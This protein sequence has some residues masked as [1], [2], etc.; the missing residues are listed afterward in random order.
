VGSGDERVDAA[1]RYGPIFGRLPDPA[2]VVAGSPARAI[3]A[4]DACAALPGGVEAVMEDPS[5]RRAID[6]REPA[7]V[8]LRDLIEASVSPLEEPGTA[9]V[10]LREA[11]AVALV[12]DVADSIGEGFCVWDHRDRL[13]FHNRRYL[14][15]FPPGNDLIRI[16]VRFEDLLR[17]IVARSGFVVPDPEEFIRRRIESRKAEYH[18][19]EVRLGTERLYRVVERR[20]PGGLLVTVWVDVTEQ[21]RADQRL[22]D[23]VESVN[24]GFSLWD[25]DGRLLLGNRRFAEL[26]PGGADP[27]AS[28][29]EILRRGFEAGLYRVQGDVDEW[30]RQRGELFA[31]GGAYEQQLSDGRWLLGSYRATSEGGVV[32]IETDV[33]V[34]KRQEL[35]LAEMAER[36]MAARDAAQEANRARSQF[37]ALMSHELRTPLNAIIGFS[38]LIETEALGP[39]GV[40]R[41]VD[42]ARDVRT[43]GSHLLALVNDLL[44][45]SKIEA[46]KY[47]LRPEPVDPVQTIRNTVRMMRLRAAEAGVDLVDRVLPGQVPTVM[48]DERALRQVLLNLLSNALKFTEPGGQVTVSA[49]TGDDLLVIEVEDTGIGIPAE[50]LGRVG[51][52]FVQVDNSHTRRHA[53]TGLGLALSRSL[54]ELHGGTL[55][56]ESEPGKGTRVIVRLP[57][58]RV[59][60]GGAAVG[61]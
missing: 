19:F 44:D 14:D 8:M 12:R 21:E 11:S 55:G 26:V 4:N 45:L 15:L 17:S 59:A 5:L 35:E 13:I 53:G 54:A 37:L 3:F 36:Y 6:A 57:L 22:R 2:L 30:I 34:M 56:I 33:S 31:R 49:R 32:G 25:G 7:R 52:P 58:R 27:G 46:G 24:E 61:A 40:E 50:Y 41:Y 47:D 42:Y 28:H 20:S 9:L 38:E 43:S 51:A 23:A 16:G 29:E 48:A 1:R 10:L 18:R 39:V 60:V